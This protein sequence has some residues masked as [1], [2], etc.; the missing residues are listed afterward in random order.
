MARFFHL[1]F[2]GGRYDAQQGIPLSS[3][4][5]LS[6]IERLVRS[7]ARDLF[8][9]GNED[10]HRV[11][12]GF[13]DVFV[14]ALTRIEGGGSADADIGWSPPPVDGNTAFFEAARTEIVE[15]LETFRQEEP[16]V[17]PWLS[18]ESAQLLAD[19]LEAIEEG[20]T[21]RWDATEGEE[22]TVGYEVRARVKRE[23]SRARPVEE[24][25]FQVV[26][27]LRRIGDDP[28][29]VGVTV[30]ETRRAITVPVQHALKPQL[31]EAWTQNERTLV[32]LTGVASRDG[33][34]RR[35]FVEADTIEVIGGP[36]LSARVE[37]LA[38][39]EDGWLGDEAPS[40]VPGRRF[41]ILVERAIWDLIEKTGVDRPH[42]FLQPDAGVEALWKRDHLSV[43]LRFSSG[44]PTQIV[45]V[46]IDRETKSLSRSE[47][48]ATL[49]QLHRWLADQLRG[50]A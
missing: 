10:R 2:Q 41:L 28:W 13:D 6:K 4:A 49:D 8:F 30:W 46:A 37:Q 12:P 15:L 27:R 16:R 18:R 48:V 40:K 47:P 9:D 3:L 7:V 42:L 29:S 38:L 26:G 22:V 19:V 5:G 35:R 11:S 14:P 36:P 24:E 31:T 32:R 25:Q 21:V 34:G 45:G 43:S 20:E 17:P 1:Y 23:A 50:T 44:P 39:I 33:D